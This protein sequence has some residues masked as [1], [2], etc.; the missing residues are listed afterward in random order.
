MIGILWPLLSTM[1][2]LPLE[3]FYF[4]GLSCIAALAFY[5][6]FEKQEVGPDI[7]F[8]FRVFQVAVLLFMALAMG[9]A[10]GLAPD[11]MRGAAAGVG[12]WLAWRVTMGIS[13][14]C[15]RTEQVS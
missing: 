6:I 10:A 12:G 14:W 5:L 15:V 7:V 8:V 1:P 2:R 9:A 3:V 13:R 4:A 11:G